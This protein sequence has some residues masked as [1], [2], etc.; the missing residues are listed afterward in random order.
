MKR[1][2]MPRDIDRRTALRFIGAAAGTVSVAGIAGANGVSRPQ[3]VETTATLTAPDGA[4]ITW[5]R[6]YDAGGSE[7]AHDVAATDD[8]Y[9]FAGAVTTD[10]ASSDAYLVETDAGGD[11]RWS[12]SFGDDGDQVLTG[13]VAVDDG[14]VVCGTADTGFVVGTDDEG[15][16]RWRTE[17]GIEVR[18]VART[19]DGGYVVAG[20]KDA[21]AGG[22]T[23]LLGK[24]GPDGAVQWTRTYEEGTPSYFNAVVQTPDGGYALAGYA[25]LNANWTLKTDGEGDREWSAAP[26]EGEALDVALTA[27]G[28]ILST[29]AVRGSGG[30]SPFLTRYGPDGTV[31]FRTQY[32]DIDASAATAVRALG[33]DTI[34]LSTRGFGL[35]V[36]DSEGEQRSFGDHD[37]QANALAALDDGSVA[38][39]GST[40]GEET[41]AVLAKTCPLTAG[42]PA[43]DESGDD[44]PADGESGDD[45]STGDGGSGSSD[46]SD[47]GDVTEGGC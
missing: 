8:G 10:R 25:G 5:R 24:L 33:D 44:E 20:R 16:E 12:T 43:E 1:G 21:S 32:D 46:E 6:T 23:P 34:V 15:T 47:D 30:F 39:A 26:R 38:V 9:V 36:T 4:T 35:L 19:A 14:Y 40:T 17:V 7:V 18:D 42:A 45:E 37:G 41:D 28:D 13:V 3:T 31:R 27:D 11:P 22:A 2:R 29:G